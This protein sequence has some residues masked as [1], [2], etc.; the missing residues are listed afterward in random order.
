MSKGKL[1]LFCGLPGTGKTTLARKLEKSESIIRLCPDE[2]IYEL[3]VDKS[4]G[5][6]MEGLRRIIEPIQW[7]LAKKLLQLGNTV[8]LENGFWSAEERTLYR[9]KAN[10]VGAVVEIYYFQVKLATLKDRLQKR[11][12]IAPVGTFKI[13][14]EDIEKWEE[15][16]EIPQKDELE[17]FDNYCVYID[18]EQKWFK[19]KI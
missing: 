2:W 19:T 8:L 18:G 13:S 16:F 10:S 4:D 1:I 9:E 11:N 5:I 15:G 12:E 6:E 7:E 14:M 17:K 3:L